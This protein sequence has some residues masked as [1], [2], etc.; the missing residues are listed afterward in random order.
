[1]EVVHVDTD[2]QWKWYT[3]ALVQNGTGACWDWTGSEGITGT[4]KDFRVILSIACCKLW[5]PTMRVSSGLWHKASLLKL[6]ELSALDHSCR[7]LIT[8]VGT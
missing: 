4:H 5:I 2:P 3:L 8:I 7:P 6:S 1:M